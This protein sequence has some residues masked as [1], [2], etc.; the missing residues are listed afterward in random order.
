MYRGAREGGWFACGVKAVAPR[1]V[2]GNARSGG[3]G[4]DGVELVTGQRV[5]VRV[6]RGRPRR[7]A[8]RLL[9]PLPS[10]HRER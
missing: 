5:C 3:D 1:V 7:K 6:Q 8:A 4:D 10:R 9:V 2:T